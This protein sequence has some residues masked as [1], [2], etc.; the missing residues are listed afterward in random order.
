MKILVVSNLYPP[1]YVGG[2]E[3]H[4]QAV[5]EALR[6]RGHSVTVLT[7]DHGSDQTSEAVTE[8]NV[9][10][11]LRVHGL[12][13]HPFLGILQL[14]ALELH[15]NQTLVSTIRQT[16]PDLVYIWNFS[17]LSKS[18]LLTLQRLGLPVVYAV[19]DFWVARSET[20][21]VWLRWWNRRDTQFKQRLLRTLWTWT[22]RRRAC[23]KL[24]P[25]NSVQH[26][27]FQRIHFCSQALRDSTA[28]EGFK[29]Q[30]AAIIYCPLNIEKFSAKPRPA[31]H[32]LQRLLYAGRLN[33]E[34]G[35]MTALRA[36]TFV[37]DKF[38]GHLS[39]YGRGEPAYEKKL[40]SFVCENKLPVTFN[41]LLNPDQMP[42]I[43]QSHDALLFTSEWNEPFALTPIEAMASGLPVIGTTT[44]GSAELFRHGENALTFSA[45]NAEELA[46]RILELDSD[47]ALRQKISCAGQNEVRARF[48]EPIIV[49]QIESY[50]ADSLQNWRPIPLPDYTA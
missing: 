15:N 1:H 25:T 42:T 45:G 5:V 40:I 12:F 29:V 27:Q 3:L 33:E 17:G 43:Y 2:Y 38:A 50:L 28:A 20:A 8:K 23:Q 47:S 37:R 9:L 16:E 44:G 48:A 35:I 18:M 32:P 36:M 13:G 31:S 22:G 30:H 41:S 19:C 49:N 14:C 7:S 4:C 21:D 11:S 10:R 34:K 39:V 6:S 46:R 26:L 24:I